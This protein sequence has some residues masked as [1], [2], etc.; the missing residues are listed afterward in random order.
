[1]KGIAVFLSLLLVKD[2]KTVNK[3]NHSQNKVPISCG[4]KKPCPKNSICL[5]IYSDVGYCMTIDK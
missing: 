4:P 2:K 3:I 1:M 5:K